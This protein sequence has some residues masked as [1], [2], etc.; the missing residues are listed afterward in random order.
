M[1]S[2]EK[3]TSLEGKSSYENLLKIGHVS[4]FLYFHFI[5][6]SVKSSSHK[7]V[8]ANE[9]EHIKKWPAFQRTTDSSFSV[10]PEHSNMS[11]GISEIK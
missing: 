7:H 9:T 2:E 4:K 11:I 3:K 1:D 10:Q 6:A 8:M 5:L